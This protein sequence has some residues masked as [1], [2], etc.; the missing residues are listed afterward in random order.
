MPTPPPTS[1][2]LL[3][4]GAGATRL[5]AVVQ[6]AR[7]ATSAASPVLRSSRSSAQMNLP[8]FAPNPLRGG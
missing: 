2:S 1:T 4:R 8:F 6:R 3:E 5:P 7:P